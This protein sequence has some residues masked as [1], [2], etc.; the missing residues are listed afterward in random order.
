MASSI[1]SQFSADSFT[2]ERAG[3]ASRKIDQYITRVEVL[4]LPQSLS[5]YFI[6]Q[7]GFCQIMRDYVGTQARQFYL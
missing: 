3:P 5:G 6:Q 4:D 1:L 2:T 7:A